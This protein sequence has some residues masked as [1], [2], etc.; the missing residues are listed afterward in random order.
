MK[1]LFIPAKSKI[2]ISKVLKKVKIKGKIG[3]VT[4]AQFLH[5][6]PKA[7][8]VLKSSIIAGQIL[9]CNA[10]VAEK[11]KNKVDVFLYIGSGKFHP[12]EVAIKTNKPV[13]IA[14][15]NTNEFSRISEEEIK[16]KKRNQKGKL[17]KFLAS[18]KIG[19][20][21]STKPFQYNLKKALILKKKLKKDSFI[22]LFNTLNIEELENF[23]DIGCWVNTACPRI[24]GKNIINVENVVPNLK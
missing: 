12:I 24:E 16:K 5:Q 7:K 22:F 6:L 23:P 8:K 14:N 11:I 13:Y 17:L 20:L 4:T 21:V 1:T 18:E 19:I 2:D 10:S 3:L 15:P 9:G